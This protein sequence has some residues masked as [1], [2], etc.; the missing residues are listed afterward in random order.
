MKEIV[1]IWRLKI[2]CRSLLVIEFTVFSFGAWVLSAS[3]AT[4]ARSQFDSQASAGSQIPALHRAWLAE[5]DQTKRRDLAGQLLEAVIHDYDAQPVEIAD[6]VARNGAPKNEIMSPIP[7][8][9]VA[10]DPVFILKDAHSKEWDYPLSPVFRRISSHR[11]EAWT[12]REGWLFN[13]NGKMVA[14]VKIPRR[15]G[16]GREWFGAF[17]PNGTWITTDL[18]GDDK[19]LNCYDSKASWLWELPGS[20]LVAR[21]PKPGTN[22]DF[23]DEPIAPSIGWARA[24]STGRRWLVCLGFDYARGYVLVDP[25]RHIQPLSYTAD[26]WN[27]VYPRNMGVRGM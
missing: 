3:A 14:D 16:S 4:D 6:E 9:V 25:A 17:L 13:A 2:M 10:L 26:I 19:Q 7:A 5:H 20:Q 27:L 22:P 21:L 1:V 15:D 18:W 11:I 24:D 23:S 12:S 8:R